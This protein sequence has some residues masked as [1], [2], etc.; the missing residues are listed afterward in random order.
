MIII[1]KTNFP[2]TIFL[3]KQIYWKEEYKEYKTNF[4]ETIFLD[5]HPIGQLNQYEK[6]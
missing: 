3:Q 5:T 1:D 4:H 2:E 6:R